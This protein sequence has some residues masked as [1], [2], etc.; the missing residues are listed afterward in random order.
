MSFS[1][2][3]R[4]RTPFRQWNHGSLTVTKVRV[5][6]AGLLAAATAI[7]AACGTASDAA[8]PPNRTTIP[9]VPVLAGAAGLTGS[10]D[11]STTKADV[12]GPACSPMPSRFLAA[13]ETAGL[14]GTAVTVFAPA[15]AALGGADPEPIL[16]HHVIG[17]RFDAKG[18][19][20]AGSVSSLDGA[21]GPVKIEGFGENMT[22]DG[23]KILCGNVPAGNATIFVI[24]RVLKPKTAT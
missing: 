11:G 13:A 15:D 3:P 7:L 10:P 21:G 22:I 14:L 8:G 24:D 1:E 23:A 4:R 19:A 5:A 18:L 6:G 9:S 12:F 2:P 20:V 16:R 17:K